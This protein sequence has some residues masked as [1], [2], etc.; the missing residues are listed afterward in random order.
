MDEQRGSQADRRL[1]QHRRSHATASQLS[2]WLSRCSKV[3]TLPQ[4]QSIKRTLLKRRTACS[5][6][7]GETSSVPRALQ[8]STAWA[9]GVPGL[10][11]ARWRS[12]AQAT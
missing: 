4:Q 2:K 9:E 3:H 8:A 11:H 10:A 12:S 1:Y 6:S 5:R 7:S